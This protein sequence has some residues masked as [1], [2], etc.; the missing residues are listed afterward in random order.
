MSEDDA[1][2]VCGSSARKKEGSDEWEVLPPP[3]QVAMKL[4]RKGKVLQRI[5]LLMTATPPEQSGE[6]NWVHGIVFDSF[7]NLYLTDIQGHRAQKFVC[8]P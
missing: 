5:P 2:W 6:L 8:E 1:I 4:N 3:D 7:G